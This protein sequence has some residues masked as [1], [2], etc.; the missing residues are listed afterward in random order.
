MADTLSWIY[1][2]AFRI[3]QIS[4]PSTDETALMIACLNSARRHAEKMIDFEL[5]K[6]RVYL[7][8]DA[9]DGGP[10]TDAH[11]SWSGSAPTGA[12]KPFTKKIRRIE[13]WD[14]TNSVWVPASLMT[15]DFYR[16]MGENVGRS[17]N[18]S[19]LW[20]RPTDY[21]D[22]VFPTRYV[23]LREGNMI[24]S[25]DE[26]STATD[27]YLRMYV[28]YFLYEYQDA[29]HD[30]SAQDTATILA[31]TDFLVE[32]CASYLTWWAVREF[33]SRSANFV[34][35]NEGSLDPAFIDARVQESW[36][37]MVAWNAD[38]SPSQNYLGAQQ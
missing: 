24:Y 9:T 34:P 25:S 16:Q 17:V 5:S 18:D 1:N 27:T 12:E 3:L 36:D 31:Q 37:A 6:E 20:T 21:P 4:S 22:T 8:I 33:N 30:E 7:T 29:L 14:S 11:A 2:N 19:S 35:R 38:L 15:Y 13:R 28:Y 26:S 32:H 10:I 23:Y